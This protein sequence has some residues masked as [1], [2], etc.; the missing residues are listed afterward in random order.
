MDNDLRRKAEELAA[1]NYSHV[2]VIEEAPSG[3]VTFMAKNPELYGCMAEGSTFEAALEN[4]AEARVDFIHSLLRD[5]LAVPA[6]ASQAAPAPR[7]A[8]TAETSSNRAHSNVT[9]AIQFRDPSKPAAEPDK[10]QPLYE[11]L[12]QTVR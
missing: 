10:S 9:G 7:G 3:Q 5:G 6:P 1:R 8:V 12:V 11:A 4:L 2:V